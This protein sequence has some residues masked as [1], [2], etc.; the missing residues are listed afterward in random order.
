MTPPPSRRKPRA[1]LAVRYDTARDRAPR[2]VAKG[3]GEMADRILSVARE[4]GVPVHEDPELVEAL[5]RLE[6]QEQ[7]PPELYQVMAEVLTFIYRTN[8]KR[9]SIL[10][11][12]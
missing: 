12:A 10:K 7:I 8:K 9:S 1:A 2:V 3:K 11:R 4:F 5:A 6:I